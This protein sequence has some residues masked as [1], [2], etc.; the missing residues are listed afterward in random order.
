MENN[1]CN[2]QEAESSKFTRLPGVNRLVK[3]PGRFV[4]QDGFYLDFHKDIWNGIK[5]I[6]HKIGVL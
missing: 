4:V 1:N 6:L 2:L 3:A 5:K